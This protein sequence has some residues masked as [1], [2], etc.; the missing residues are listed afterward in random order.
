MAVDVLPAQELVA[1]RRGILE[2]P[3]EPGIIDPLRREQDGSARRGRP[4]PQS[5]P[6]FAGRAFGLP[7]AQLVTE[8]HFQFAA[9]ETLVLLVVVDVIHVAIQ[10]GR[11]VG[12]E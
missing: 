5:A 4:L 8:D 11:A 10:A 12:P 7:S 9:G 6:R 1:Q 3:E 2:R